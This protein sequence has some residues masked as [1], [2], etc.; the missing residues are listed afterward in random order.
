VV[1]L[2]A[3]VTGS[4]GSTPT[5]GDVEFAVGKRH[6]VATVPLDENGVAEADVTLPDPR[7]RTVK[8]FYSGDDTYAKSHSDRVLITPEPPFDP[9]I[10]T[11]WTPLKTRTDGS[12][13]YLIGVTLGYAK[14][15]APHGAVTADRGFDCFE[16]LRPNAFRWKCKGRATPPAT[17]TVSYTGDDNFLPGSAKV[18]LQ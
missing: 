18:H 14:N 15:V 17:V 13:V 4:G 5:G 11:Y 8:A 9:N 2:V 3:T 1:H 7:A 12:V 6:V 10:H 16:I